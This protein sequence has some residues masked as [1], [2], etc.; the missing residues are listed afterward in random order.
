MPGTE[1]EA[2]AMLAKGDLKFRLRRQEAEGR[3]RAGQDE[4]PASGKQGQRMAADQEARRLLRSRDTTSTQFDESVLS[5]RSLAEI[6]GDADRR[7][8]RAVRQGGGN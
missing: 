1:A 2:A 6:A 3:L 5:K 4:R 7:S 8:G